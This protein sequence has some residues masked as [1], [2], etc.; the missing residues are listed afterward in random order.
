MSSPLLVFLYV[1]TD[2]YHFN[3]NGVPELTFSEDQDSDHLYRRRATNPPV[4]HPAADDTIK[5]TYQHLELWV[6]TM[7]Q[8]IFNLNDTLDSPTT[9]SY[10][11]FRQDLK[12][13]MTGYEVEATCHVLFDT[14]IDRC[15]FSFRGAAKDNLVLNPSEGY[16]DDRDGNCLKRIANVT[17][18]LRFSNRICRDVM[19]KAYNCIKLASAPLSY[20]R[21]KQKLK[22]ERDLKTHTSGINTEYNGETHAGV[23]ENFINQ[24]NGTFEQCLCRF[25]AFHLRCTHHRQRALPTLLAPILW[26]ASSTVD[27]DSDETIDASESLVGVQNRPNP[28]SLSSSSSYRTLQPNLVDNQHSVTSKI[29][30]QRSVNTILR[31]GRRQP[32]CHGPIDAHVQRANNNT[33]EVCH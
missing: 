4:L 26:S 31:A 7:V 10:R 14:V 28:T 18:A 3:D 1:S 12:I 21:Q 33:P 5:R 25:Y 11:M 17:A 32:S 2:L 24:Q 22:T 8:A 27:Y 15:Y 9:P 16:M 19:Y 23:I 29:L 6:S 20:L 13:V 30:A